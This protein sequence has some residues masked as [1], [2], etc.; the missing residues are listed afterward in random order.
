MSHKFLIVSTV[1]LFGS[2]PGLAQTTT[3]PTTQSKAN[4]RSL[5]VTGC[6]AK[7]ADANTFLLTKVP[8][9]LVDSVAASGG[10]AVPT[11]TYQLS[12]GQNLAAHVG[13]KVEI[14]GR[15]P[16]KPQTPTKVT[17]TETKY[18]AAGKNGPSAE[19]KEKAAIAVRPLMVESFK[20][21]SVDCAGK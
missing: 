17:D 15:G 16:L 8:D 2:M 11:V 19:V 6:L 1:L 18:A 9:P 7:G 4:P 13:H 20:M 5:T 10:G 21:V 14:T 3:T 12:G